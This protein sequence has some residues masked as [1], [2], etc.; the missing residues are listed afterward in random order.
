MWHDIVP[1]AIP[2]NMWR[3]IRKITAWIFLQVCRCPDDSKC[4]AGGNGPGASARQMR[5]VKNL[6]APVKRGRES[7]PYTT[8]QLMIGLCDRRSPSPVAE[9]SIQFS[10]QAKPVIAGARQ[11]RR[12]EGN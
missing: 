8:L 1:Q 4:N 7:E 10:A 6:K 9:S 5:G 2:W 12:L 11:T 3:A